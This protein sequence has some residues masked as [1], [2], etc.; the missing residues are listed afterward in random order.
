M[1]KRELRGGNVSQVVVTD[2]VVTRTK[3]LAYSGG[4]VV[5]ITGS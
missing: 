4:N 1:C 2:G 5:S 3:T